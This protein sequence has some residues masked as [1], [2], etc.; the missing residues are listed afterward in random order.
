MSLDKYG[1]LAPASLQDGL[2][3]FRNRG[4]SG[5]QIEVGCGNG[6]FLPWLAESHPDHHILGIEKDLIWARKAGRKTKNLQNCSAM[7][8][9]ATML[10][11]QIKGLGRADGIW[12]NFP[13]PWPKLKHSERRLASGRFRNQLETALADQGV[14]HLATDVQSYF[15]EM[16]KLFG[17]SENWVLLSDPP[18]ANVPVRTRFEQKW[19]DDGRP[20]YFLGARL[21][22]AQSVADKDPLDT[23]WLHSQLAER[24]AIQRPRGSELR[25]NGFLIRNLGTRRDSVAQF[26]VAHTGESAH[27]RAH[28]QEQDG[29]WVWLNSDMWVPGCDECALLADFLTA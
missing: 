25:R 28:L 12:M 5:V 11:R 1:L 27:L 24:D 23:Q 3:G 9:D 4:A 26:I 8:Y 7:C 17:E 16:Q 15:L 13:D 2:S 14:F 22:S 6:S 10:F 29:H 18:R 21:L 19:L 20:L